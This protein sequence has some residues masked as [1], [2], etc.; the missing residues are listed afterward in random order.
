MAGRPVIVTADREFN[1]YILKQDGKLVDTWSLDTFAQVFDQASQ[2]SRKY[3]RNLTLNHFGVEAL[4]EKLIP[5]MEDM[6]SKTLADW[7]SRDSVEVKS[8]SIT[9]RE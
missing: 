9:V 7:S 4:K 3:T 5:R 1:Y 8:A 6:V 2:S